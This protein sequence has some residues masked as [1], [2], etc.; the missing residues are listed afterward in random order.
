MALYGGAE[1]V[2]VRLANYLQDRGHKVSILT[3]STKHR[4]EYEELNFIVPEQT[5]QMQYR[6][7]G[8]IEA[9]KDVYKMYITLN[10]LCKQHIEDFDVVNVH[11]F[12]SVWT[13]PR[14]KKIVWMCNEIPDL[15][16]SAGDGK[17]S[18]KLFDI[19]RLTDRMIVRHK[20][21][22]AV[23][24][25]A[26]SAKRFQHRYGITPKTIPYGIDGNFFAEPVNVD[27]D[28]FTILQPSMISP[29]KN[30]M[31]VLKAVKQLRHTIPN[32]KVVFAGYKEQTPYL[33]QL[34]QYVAEHNLNV[35]FTG[36]LSKQELRVL[37]NTAYV[38]V[39]PGKGQ[40]SWLGPFEALATGC[41]V[42]VSPNLS[43]KDTLGNLGV[44]SDNLVGTIQNVHRDYR[45]FK[46]QALKGQQFVLNNLTWDKF[47]AKFLEV[48]ES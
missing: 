44:V 19:G 46:A 42:I 14:H 13:I 36:Q 2:I 26:P 41:P 28:D 33:K 34:K 47:G 35:V 17:L 11:N 7:R 9:L 38:A 30:Q 23:V 24:P 32:I 27:R 45:L 12:P 43:C 15:W 22:T 21:P 4:K 40:G 10:R 39:F 20:R 25:D 48:L 3:L 37:Y 29:S 31:T 6:L 18:N 5:R 1:V 16:H 8:S